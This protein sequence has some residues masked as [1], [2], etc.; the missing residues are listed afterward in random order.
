[1]SRWTTC[2]TSGIWV[3]KG[4]YKWGRG[5]RTPLRPGSIW[6]ICGMICFLGCRFSSIGC[7][8]LVFHLRIWLSRTCERCTTW[9]PRIGNVF[10]NIVFILQI[11][12]CG[13][14]LAFGTCLR[15]DEWNKTI[16]HLRMRFQGFEK[17][18]SSQFLD[19]WADGLFLKADWA[20]GLREVLASLRSWY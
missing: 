1:M 17:G 14:D 6:I 15:E 13:W 3:G 12:W 18:A 11:P 2:F 20:K 8:T 4:F 10:G 9:F 7:S 5:A 16:F 19:L